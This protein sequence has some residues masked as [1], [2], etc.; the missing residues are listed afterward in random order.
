[1]SRSRLGP[2]RDE[3]NDALIQAYE[4]AGLTYEPLSGDELISTL[5]RLERKLLGVV[6]ALTEEPRIVMLED[7]DD[8]RAAEDIALLWSALTSLLEGR[9]VTLVASVQSVSAAPTPSSRLHL[10]EL[11][12]HRTL[13]ELMF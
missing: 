4:S 5:S 13:Q 11:D 8:L 12:T 7:V 10:L 9:E 3:L 6:L 2:I 1:V